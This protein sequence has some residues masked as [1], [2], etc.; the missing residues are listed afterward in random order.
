M[1]ISRSSGILDVMVTA[2]RS[3]SILVLIPILWINFQKELSSLDQEGVRH[4]LSRF[5]NGAFLIYQLLLLTDVYMML[6]RARAIYLGRLTR[7]GKAD[8]CLIMCALSKR[9]SKPTSY[10]AID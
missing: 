7:Q 5:R 8:G 9:Y 6:S 1:P 2:Q 4:G 3:I 10:P